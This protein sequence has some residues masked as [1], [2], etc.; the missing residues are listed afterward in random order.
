MKECK[1]MIPGHTINDKI[2]VKN[3]PNLMKEIY[4]QLQDTQNM[5]F[6]QSHQEEKREY[7]NK[8]YK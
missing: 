6:G 3:F 1:V 7:P 4:N 2:M 5:Y 8:Q